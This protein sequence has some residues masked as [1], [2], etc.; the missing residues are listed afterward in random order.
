M[1]GI[2]PYLLVPQ[3]GSSFVLVNP[4]MICYHRVMM[5][6]NQKIFLTFLFLSFLYAPSALQAANSQTAWVKT[7]VASDTFTGKVVGVSDGDTISVMRGGRGVKV[8]LHGIDCREKRQA[9][10]TR[11]KQFTSDM[12]FGIKA[13]YRL[14]RL[15]KPYYFLTTTEISN[16]EE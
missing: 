9:F 1:L 16:W 14:W 8:R 11:A 4:V 13:G 2:L 5:G 10:G 12:A 3:L 15:Y 6:P 7:V